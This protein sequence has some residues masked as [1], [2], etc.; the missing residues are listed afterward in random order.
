MRRKTKTD[1]SVENLAAK[2]DGLGKGQEDSQ[3]RL[4][5]DEDCEDCN[6]DEKLEQGRQLRLFVEDES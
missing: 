1:P 4:F 3:L 6:S 2:L 5:G